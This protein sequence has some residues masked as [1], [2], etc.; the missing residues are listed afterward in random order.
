MV[1]SEAWKH[2]LS[3]STPGFTLD[4]FDLVFLPG[5]HEKSIRQILDCAEVHRLVVDYFPKTKKPSNKYIGA[6]CHGVMVL[7]N[8]KREDGKSPLHGCVTTSLPSGFESSVYWG[9]RA[10]LG[11]YYKTYGTGS[12]DVEVAVCF[13]SLVR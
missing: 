7:S 12:D 6:I 9:T 3:W 5:G 10:F 13:F 8:A 4:D 1:T 2:P 11:D